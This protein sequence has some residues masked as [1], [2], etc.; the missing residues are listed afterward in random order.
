MSK[1]IATIPLADI[2]RIAIVTGN[3]RSMRRSRGTRITSA[4]PGFTT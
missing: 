2:E 4:T 1:Y 3:G